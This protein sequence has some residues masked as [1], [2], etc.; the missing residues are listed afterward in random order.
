MSRTEKTFRCP[1]DGRAV[2]RIE[3]SDQKR[4]LILPSSRDRHTADLRE[5]LAEA[6]AEWELDRERYARIFG[7]A[8]F[9]RL[10]AKWRNYAPDAPEN[11][12]YPERRFEIPSELDLGFK[13]LGKPGIGYTAVCPRCQSKS[14]FTVAS[15]E[16]DKYVVLVS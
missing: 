3:I 7:E 15:V 10:L 11:K 12:V 16:N 9:E 13:A 6:V 2:A 14:V 4:W 1:K 8:N 5:E